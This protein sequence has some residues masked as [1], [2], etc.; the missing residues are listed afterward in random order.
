MHPSWK[1]A[2]QADWWETGS[3]ARVQKHT[4]DD[5]MLSYLLSERSLIACVCAVIFSS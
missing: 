4:T 5:I 1:R 2:E 3:V